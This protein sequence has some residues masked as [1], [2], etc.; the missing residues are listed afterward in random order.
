LTENV[1]DMSG[2]GFQGK[3]VAGG[4]EPTREKGAMDRKKGIEKEKGGITKGTVEAINVN[5]EFKTQ[6]KNLVEGGGGG[7]L[8]G[9]AF[10]KKKSVKGE[11]RGQREKNTEKQQGRRERD[12]S[13]GA[14]TH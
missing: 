4:A 7:K 1:F 11:V 14:W 5:F 12:R 2:R 8:Q 6:K 13:N 3:G 9:I 10:Q